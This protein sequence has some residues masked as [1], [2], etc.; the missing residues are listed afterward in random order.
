MVIVLPWE[1]TPLGMEMDLEPLSLPP[2]LQ[3]LRISVHCGIRADLMQTRGHLLPPCVWVQR[4]E[5]CYLPACVSAPQVLLGHRG[6]ASV[7]VCVCKRARAGTTSPP[8]SYFQASFLQN[9][10]PLCLS[11]LS[12]DKEERLSM[13]NLS[14]TSA[15]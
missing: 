3:A 11:H 8:L 10:C 4:L 13:W 1:Q 12:R 14:K 7:C 9:S 2:S 5:G 6:H 15:L